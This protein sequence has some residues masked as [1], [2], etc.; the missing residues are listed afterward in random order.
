MSDVEFS[1]NLGVQPEQV[2][3]VGEH[4]FTGRR[5]LN[6]HSAAAN[7]QWHGH[8]RALWRGDSRGEIVAH[9]FFEAWKAADPAVSDP[10]KTGNGEGKRGFA[11]CGACSGRPK[12]L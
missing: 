8:M 3:A 10:P 1:R 6:K 2:P 5:G 9:V 4:A 12:S 11:K 7:S